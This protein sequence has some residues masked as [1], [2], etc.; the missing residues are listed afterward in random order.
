[1]LLRERAWIRWVWVPPNGLNFAFAQGDLHRAVRRTVPS[2]CLPRTK[3]GQHLLRWSS[4]VHDA[5]TA[6]GFLRPA[7]R[8]GLP[9]GGRAT[10]TAT[11]IVQ[12]GLWGSSP[13]ALIL[14]C[15]LGLHTALPV[16]V[17]S[18][19]TS[20]ATEALLTNAFMAFSYGNTRP[21]T[22]SH[23]GVAQRATSPLHLLM[24]RTFAG[25]VRSALSTAGRCRPE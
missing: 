8:A 19:Q 14:I 1:M 22:S 2:F 11:L 9:G 13:G 17:R 18:L 6:A 7:L 23:D 21:T 4:T 15:V 12:S 16:V 10:T 20:D 5:A 24:P 25:A 3:V